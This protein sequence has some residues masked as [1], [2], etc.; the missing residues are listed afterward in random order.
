MV[1]GGAPPAEFAGW[2]G[3]VITSVRVLGPV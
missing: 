2:A 3:A 1:T